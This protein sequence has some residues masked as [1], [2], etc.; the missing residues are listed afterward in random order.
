MESHYPLQPHQVYQSQPDLHGNNHP[1]GETSHHHTFSSDFDFT[2]P[3]SSGFNHQYGSPTYQTFTAAPMMQHLNATTL[4]PSQLTN[5]SPPPTGSPP[6]AIPGQLNRVGLTAEESTGDQTPAHP[7]SPPPTSKA[8]QNPRKTLSDAD[9]R[10][11]C[12]FAL[13]NPAIKQ[14]EIGCKSHASCLLRAYAKRLPAMFGVERRLAH[15]AP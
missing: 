5:P 6:N 2:L 3:V 7:A 12:R 1:S 11:M 14:T 8:S 9:R 4:W 10:R 13:E 15:C